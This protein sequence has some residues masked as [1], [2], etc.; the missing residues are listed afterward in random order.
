M[1]EKKYN[2]FRSSL[3]VLARKIETQMKNETGCCGVTLSQC[4]I[5]L[6][7]YPDQEL[8]IKEL[9]QRL[10]LDKSNISRTVDSMVEMGLAERSHSLDDRR[11]VSI[12]LSEKGIEKAS[13]INQSCNEYYISLFKPLSPEKQAVILQGMEYLAQLMKNESKKSCSSC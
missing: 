8:S 10:E 3:R 1:D 7:L 4:H 11:F 12:R 6:E 13:F 2:Q 9:S 5:L